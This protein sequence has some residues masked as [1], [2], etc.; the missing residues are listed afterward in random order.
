M[1]YMVI[2]SDLLNEEIVVT[3]KPCIIK[4][5]H[6]KLVRYTVREALEVANK[7]NGHP[8]DVILIHKL[9]RAFNGQIEDAEDVDE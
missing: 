4:E 7:T 1:K 6:R 2:Y 5:E 9:K 8:E 3:F